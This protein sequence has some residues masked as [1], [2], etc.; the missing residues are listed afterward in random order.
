MGA[1]SKLGCSESSL[2]GASYYKLP[3]VLEWFTGSINLHPAHHFRPE[4]PNYNLQWFHD[5]VPFLQTVE[6]LT[7]RRS[8]KS[9]RLSLWDEKGQNLVSFRTI[10]RHLQQTES[11]G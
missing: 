8:L 2:K 11:K 3:K 9:L 10:K 5:T 1:P 7:I 6:P 4:I